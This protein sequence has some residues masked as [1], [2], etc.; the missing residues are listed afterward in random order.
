MVKFNFPVTPTI[1]VTTSKT[2]N[3][4]RNIG[5]VLNLFTVHKVRWQTNNA[6]SVELIEITEGQLTRRNVGYQN[7][8]KEYEGYTPPK[9]TFILTPFNPLLD[10]IERNV[11]NIFPSENGLHNNEY[12][13]S[14]NNQYRLLLTKYGNLII[15][16][17]SDYSIVWETNTGGK[18]V[19]SVRFQ[20]DGNFVLYKN[21]ATTGVDNAVWALNKDNHNGSKKLSDNE[22]NSITQIVL[23]DVGVLEAKDANGNII[24]SS[25]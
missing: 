19:T 24:W 8:F 2:E 21:G 16:R 25:K 17:K 9:L 11:F 20:T 12:Y 18:N 7:Q 22:F 3:N 5:G 10:R 23:S 6:K 4:Q 14:D 1:T 13:D 15:L